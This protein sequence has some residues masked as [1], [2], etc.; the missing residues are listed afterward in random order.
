MLLSTRA[1]SC[2]VPTPTCTPPACLPWRV[3]EPGLRLGTPHS[4]NP[5]LAPASRQPRGESAPVGRTP[6]ASRP[7]AEQ[8]V[9]N[10]RVSCLSLGGAAQ[11]R[12]AA[13]LLVCDC[14]R[15][16]AMT[17]SLRAHVL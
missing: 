9:G 4:A 13:S 16:G 8:Q 11:T 14:A 3:Q 2:H 5:A 17:W 10:G 1:S 6:T 15:A 7:V 12:D